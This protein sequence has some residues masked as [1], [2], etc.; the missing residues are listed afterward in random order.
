MSLDQIITLQLPDNSVGQMLDGLDVLI[1]Q[2]EATER[3]H[4]SGE[5]E[6]DVCIRECTDAEEAASIAAMY[7]EI[8]AQIEEQ[9]LA[10]RPKTTG[11]L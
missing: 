8:K 9:Y 2:W 4:A 3:Y 6:E 11:G 5:V 7:L 10:Q 1:E